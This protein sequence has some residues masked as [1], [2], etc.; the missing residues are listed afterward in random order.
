MKRNWKSITVLCWALL[1]IT[2]ITV[3]ADEAKDIDWRAAAQKEKLTEEDIQILNKNG[4]I[5]TNQ[6]YKQVFEAYLEGT[7]P[8]FITSD[9]LLN[10]YHVLYEES[11]LRLEDANAKKLPD[12]LRTIH[13]NLSTADKKWKGRPQLV[14]AAKKRAAIIIGTALRLVD[15]SFRTGDKELDA[16]I[17]R[18]TK[19][20][21]E[22]KAKE[23]PAWLGKPDRTLFALDY[24]RYKPRGFY[25]RSEKLERHFRA[26]AWLQS[27]P[28]RVSKDEELVSIMML[29]SCVP[30]R[31]S[32][33]PLSQ[34]MEY[35]QFFRA[36]R[37]FIGSGDDWDVI[38]AAD[39]VGSG[40]RL[41]LA[42]DGLG[43]LR[44]QL[45]EKASK[46]GKGPQIND[47]LRFAPDDPNLT[48]EAN[49]RIISAYRTPDAILF[50]RTTDL[51]RF[52]RELPNGLEVCTALGSAFAREKLTYKD[53]AKLLRTIDE[54]KGLFSGDSLYL[55]Y[56]ECLAALLD[57]PEEDAPSFMRSRAWD[58]KS[59]NT[60]LGGW[61]QLRHTWSLQ[62][63]LA[64]YYMCAT[65][66]PKGFVEPEPE[67]YS[68]MALLAKKTQGILEQPDIFA[69][70][71]KPLW[72]SLGEIS[73]RLEM[74]A[75]KQLRGEDWNEQ[76]E[77]F[78]RG[79]GVR[80]AKIMLYSGNSY[81]T[82]I[83]DAP[84]IVDVYANPYIPKG[85]LHA[86]IARPRAI[87]VLYP[88]HGNLI[89]CKGAV[90][91][92]Y[93][94]GYDG[95]LTDTEWK[96]SLDSDKRPTVPDWL[97]PIISERGISKP[98]LESRW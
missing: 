87:Y 26:V 29:G 30:I 2:G 53:K 24:S 35:I 52:D 96:K 76:D 14:T 32:A 88:W 33:R 63:K 51:R 74:L 95:M 69:L 23:M 79:Y 71:L 9:S 56:L 31:D 61:A 46:Y 77:R 65:R 3:V 81:V 91:P 58:S 67:F 49:F 86:G 70:D 1:A 28:F 36:Y 21:V 12:I 54:T 45:N 78:I 47:Q 62:A 27:I 82:P 44:S 92:Y 97:K 16:I 84:R 94:F 98:I 18:E 93:E 40:L 42:G 37:M 75:H 48:A 5:I 13:E 64:A 43:N 11:V 68:R 20:I 80:I 8:F 25:T 72:K 55:G 4:I 90:L 59:C 50:H 6:A 60:A 34:A 57:E 22:A 83:D 41:D 15:E 10:A 85:Y 38:T 17:E 39:E 7:V 19:K 66:A 73:R 89:L